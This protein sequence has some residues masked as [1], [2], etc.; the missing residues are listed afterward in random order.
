MALCC[1][2]CTCTCSFLSIYLSSCKL[3]NEA[4]QRDF[5]SFWTWQHQK[6]SNSARLPQFLN[7]TRS[8]TK[9]FCETSS[10]FEV[11]DIKSEAILRDFLQKYKVECR[12]QGLVPMRFAIFH[13]IYLQYCACHETVRPGHT[14]CCTCHTKASYQNLKIWC[15]KMPPLSGN[16]HP[17]L[18]TCL[19][20]VSLVLRLP[21]D[22]HLCRSSSNAPRLPTLLK[23]SQNPHVLHAFGRVQN[24]LRLQHKTTLQRQKVARTCGVFGI[25]TS[26]CASRHN[27]VYFWT[28]QLPQVLWGRQFFTPLLTFKCASRQNGVHFFN[29]STCKSAPTLWYF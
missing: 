28:S 10:I 16:Q 23:L 7:L 15:S 5:L 14:K 20:H 6:R 19:T 3:E 18:L 8:K 2:S 24:P 9:Q 27:G 12:A 4:I 21:R 17:D 29:I 11:D 26:K 22:M 25:L 1:C 13:S